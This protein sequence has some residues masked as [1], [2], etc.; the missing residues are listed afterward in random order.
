MRS[1]IHHCILFLLY[2]ASSF[3]HGWTAEWVQLK[4]KQNVQPARS[5]HVAFQFTKDDV[6]VFGGY[7]EVA[8]KDGEVERYP[9]NDLWK[10]DP[11]ETTWTLVK[12]AELYVDDCEECNESNKTPQQRL[13]A[14]ASTLDDSAFI[15]GGWDPQTPG[16]GGVILDS[17]SEYSASKGEWMGPTLASTALEETTSRHVTVSISDD[18]IL[19][20]NHR[21]S[22]YVLL[23]QKD[24]AARDYSLH[25][26]PTKGT[27]PSPRGLH[28][29]CKLGDNH[30]VV[31][32]G[33]A[34]DQSMSNEVFVLNL[35]SWT[36]KKLDSATSSTPVPRASPCLCALDDTTCILFGGATPSAT[37]GLEGLNDLWLMKTDIKKGS[38]SWKKLDI[39][40][41]ATIP[42]GRNAATLMP[43][44][45]QNVDN[46][47]C[48]LLSG[49]WAPFVKTHND[50]FVLKVSPEP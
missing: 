13:A 40:E 34:Q 1:L 21:C 15:F 20:H 46:C 12:A 27:G 37:M 24:S 33:A 7:A 19:L 36:W 49:G 16:T 25:R 10:F 29:A 22:D 32:G 42:P 14:S 43:V 48:F 2:P 18:S 31:F 41:S 3:C 47:Q 39:A 6:Y 23:F 44:D 4:P 11:A 38:V 45:L 26:Q 8:S 30:I 9:T 50:S 17:V 5:G 35:S 28:A